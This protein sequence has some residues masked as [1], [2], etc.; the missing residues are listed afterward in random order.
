MSDLAKTFKAL[1]LAQ[2][3]ARVKREGEYL[4]SK[5]HG[6]HNVH[7][8]RMNGFFSE[9]W[10]RIGHDQVEWIEVQQNPELLSEY[11]R[12]DLQAILDRI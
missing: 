12:L 2:R 11:V 9:V 3:L 4:D 10:M 5:R 7:L 1:P 6:G 8:Y